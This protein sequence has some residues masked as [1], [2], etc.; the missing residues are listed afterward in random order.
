VKKLETSRRARACICDCSYVYAK[1]KKRKRMT[2]RRRIND[3][4]VN[5]GYAKGEWERQEQIAFATTINCDT[6]TLFWRAKVISCVA[7]RRLS[8][9]CLV[10]YPDDARRDALDIIFDKQIDLVLRLKYRYVWISNAARNRERTEETSS[11]LHVTHFHFLPRSPELKEKGNRK[12]R[13]DRRQRACTKG[14]ERP[15]RKAE[16]K[17]HRGHARGANGTRR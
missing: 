7:I 1:R 17:K 15:R 2:Y 10:M 14:H 9:M 16:R 5:G 4:Q 13:R 11:N 8:F 3:G 6:K 12:E